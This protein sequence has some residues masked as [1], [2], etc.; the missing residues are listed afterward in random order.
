MDTNSKETMNNSKEIST[1]FNSFAIYT[2]NKKKT[3]ISYTP[4]A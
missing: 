3:T 2:V 1:T 4:M